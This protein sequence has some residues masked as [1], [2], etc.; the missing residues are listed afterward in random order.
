MLI[1]VHSCD[2]FSLP[3]DRL[4]AYFKVGLSGYTNPTRNR[5]IFCLCSSSI[6]IMCREGTY[7]FLVDNHFDECHYYLRYRITACTFHK[8]VVP[9]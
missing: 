7:G 8:H 9:I 3:K 6:Y 4:F 2:F 1:H 5:L